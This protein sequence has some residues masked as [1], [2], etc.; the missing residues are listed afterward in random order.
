MDDMMLT[1]VKEYLTNGESKL[2][3]NLLSQAVKEIVLLMDK[4]NNYK[5]YPE[6]RLLSMSDKFLAQYRIN[7]DDAYLIISKIFRRAAHKIYRLL[8]KKHL[9][10]KNDSFLNL[11]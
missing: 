3:K 9:I 7:G 2:Y 4:N 11:V 6:K 8:L 1:L 10:T 5:I